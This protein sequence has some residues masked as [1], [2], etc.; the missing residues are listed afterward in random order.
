MNIYD[1]FTRQVEQR[2]GAAALTEWRR[3]RPVTL[4][5]L[6]LERAAARAAAMLTAGGL[7]AGDPV[8]VFVPMSIDLYVALLAILRLRLV[9]VFLDPS[10]GRQH[11][12]RCCEDLSAQGPDRHPESAPA[13][14]H[15][16]GP[17]AHTDRVWH[18]ASAP[19]GR[20]ALGPVESICAVYE[21]RALRPGHPGPG[22]LHERKHRPAEGRRAQPRAA[23]G[24]AAEPGSRAADSAAATSS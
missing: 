12:E 23:G 10:A 11:I 15:Q 16:P 24:A 5:F 6:E 8:L 19:A 14:L 20:A 7:K 1:L 3:N 17:S 21:S 13:A 4:S 2:P 22:D 9:A 18:R